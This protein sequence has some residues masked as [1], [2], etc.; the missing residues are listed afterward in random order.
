MHV[1]RKRSPAAGAVCSGLE[2]KGRRTLPAMLTGLLAGVTAAPTPQR[3]ARENPYMDCSGVALCGVV[4]L[5]TGLGSGTY[6]HETPGVHGLWPE[7]GSYGSSKCIAPS[8]SKTDPS[9]VYTCY[10]QPDT[11]KADQLSFEKHEWDKHGQCA[12]VQDAD[13]FFGQICKL[14]KAPLA[15]MSEARK[16]GHIDLAGYAQRL[17]QA[18]YPVYSTDEQNMQVQLSACAG[19]DGKWVLAKP[20]AFSSTCLA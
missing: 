2:R 17:T 10:N 3:S 1:L 4:V 15:V 18:G 20:E 9:Q 16:E 8:S 12:G 19:S 13:D 5:E 7:V 6:H 14:T 11:S